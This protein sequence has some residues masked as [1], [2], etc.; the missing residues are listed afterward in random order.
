MK[1]LLLITLL[2][3]ACVATAQIDLNTIL[4]STLG[5]G[6]SE[7]DI[8]KG[9][10]QALTVG[11]QNAGTQASALDGFYKNDL[12]KIPFPKEAEQMKST[13]E[14]LGLKQQVDDFEKQLNRAA[15]DA[16]VKAAPVFINAI[17]SMN[18]NDGLSILRGN[19]D[20]AT[21]YLKNATTAELTNQFK[22]IIAASLKKV[23]ITNYWN[24]LF[25]AYDKIPFVNHINPNLDDYV[26][27]KAI[28]GLFKL[29]A[30]EELKIRQ[31][32]AARVTPTLKKVF[33]Q[34][35]K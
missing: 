6:L 19:N 17:T 34:K 35:K 29:V 24:P 31:V 10:K 23:Q 16:A 4:N 13:L 33:K 18:V 25:S 2:A 20:A 26:T 28:E 12:I 11:I 32:P 8:V 14:G 5:K 21:Q 22:P 15:E 7:K 9:I 3:T 30:Q 1:K 27:G